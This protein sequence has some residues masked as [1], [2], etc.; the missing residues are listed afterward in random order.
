MLATIL[1]ESNNTARTSG[2]GIKISRM[3]NG[4]YGRIGKRLTESYQ[5]ENV[6]IIGQANPVLT[7]YPPKILETH[8]D[9]QN[10]RV[11]LENNKHNQ[12]GTQENSRN[13]LLV[14]K[15]SG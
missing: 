1:P 8:D 10:N 9:R 13:H 7:L 4:I 5:F 11:D 14:M 15:E 6:F 2:S 12:K 3:P